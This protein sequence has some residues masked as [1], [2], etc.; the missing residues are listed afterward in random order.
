MGKPGVGGGGGGGGG[1]NGL[2]AE[3]AAMWVLGLVN[4]TGLGHWET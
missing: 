4:I 2:K 1:T 3:G